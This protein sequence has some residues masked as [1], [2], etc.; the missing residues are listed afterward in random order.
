MSNER[1]QILTMLKDG[2]ITVEEAE[3][4][5]T[6]V[7]EEKQSSG[8]KADGVE[9]PKSL[10][11]LRIIE[12]REGTGEEDYERQLN[13]RIPLALLRAGAKLHSVLPANAREK[14]ESALREKWSG[15]GKNLLETG[16]I[17]LITKALSEEGISVE[18]DRP[19]KKISIFCE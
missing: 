17:E 12:K 5:L 10:K 4:L 9:P 13:I 14:V 19:D 6:A 3:K 15:V 8:A 1:V 18:I 11:Y 2:K 7:G 16:D